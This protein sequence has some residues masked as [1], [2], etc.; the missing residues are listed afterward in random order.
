MRKEM[1]SVKKLSLAT[2]L[3]YT[4]LQV[5][6]Q[7]QELGEKPS[8]WKDK[9]KLE[10]DSNS[11]LYAFKNGSVNGH[12]R[13]FFMATDNQTGLS[14]YHAHAGGGG[15]KFET[16]RFKGFQLGISGFFTFNMASSD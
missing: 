13:Y 10:I 2:L 9:E 3:L 12:L 5:S 1:L 7:H 16:A 8:I 14:D 11:L 6:G 4:S 15:I